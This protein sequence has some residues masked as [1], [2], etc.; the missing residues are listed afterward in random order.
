MS[1]S[2]RRR[3]ALLCRR[4]DASA[5]APA[6][7]TGC[8]TACSRCCSIS[9]NCR[10]S[11]ATAAAVLGRS[12]QPVQLLRDTRPRRWRRQ[13]GR[14]RLVEASCARP[15]C[16]RRARSACSAMPRILGYVFNPL[17]V[18]FCYAHDGALRAILYEVN[19]TFGERHSYLIP[20][21]AGRHGGGCSTR[22]APSASMSRRFS[23]ST[24]ATRFASSAAGA[25]RWPCAI[26]ASASDAGRRW[27]PRVSATRRPLTD[28]RRCACAS[29]SASALTFKV[30]AGIHW[31]ALRL[32]LKGVR[33]QRPRAE[34]RRGH[35]AR[36][37]A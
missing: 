31:E 36:T 1:A 8:T 12:L 19:N 18:Y 10:R 3:S 32:W 27:S 25:T 21:D 13:L 37:R 14:A 6:R 20:V 11:I 9:T 23:T 26:D 17:S 22:H 24:C 16:R 34:P 4:G 28:R 5:A 33:L 30:F 15:A 2:E 7:G 35:D 29:S